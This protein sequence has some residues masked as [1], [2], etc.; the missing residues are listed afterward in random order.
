MT[1]GELSYGAPLV[2]VYEGDTAWVH[3]GSYV[4]I[5]EEVVFLVGGNHRVDWVSVFP[6]R[7]RLRLQG[8]LEDGHPATKGD[9]AVGHDVWIGRGATIL[10]GVTVGNGAVVAAASV[11][12][13]DVRPYAVVA[14]N[15]AREVKRRFTDDQ[16]AALEQI[17]WWDWPP[18][19]VLERVSE[20][21]GAD[22][23]VFVS[24]Y[25][26]AIEEGDG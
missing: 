17:A 10:S 11:V 9:I 8:A 15:P 7:A 13:R 1:V 22:I 26:A 16:V 3:V 19:Q 25:S 24:R 18:E 2:Q 20:L 23:G 12:T 6:F 4:S 14:G 21:N 5:A